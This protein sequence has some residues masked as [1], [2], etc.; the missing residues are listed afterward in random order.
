M[1]FPIQTIPFFG[2][3][4]NTA[5]VPWYGPT[6]R[7]PLESWKTDGQVQYMLPFGLL[8]GLLTRRHW[9]QMCQG[10]VKTGW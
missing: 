8:L 6:D 5:M 3:P 9:L 2:I 4:R 7:R 1:F 10:Q